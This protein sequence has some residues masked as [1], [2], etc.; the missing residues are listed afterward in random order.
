MTASHDKARAERWARNNRR[1]AAQDGVVKALEGLIYTST[2]EPFASWL[3]GRSGL[4]PNNSFNKGRAALDE[5]RAAEGK[6]PPMTEEETES[7]ERQG[8]ADVRRE[9]LEEPFD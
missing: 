7:E 6:T 3:A 1:A 9:S 8:A 5:L 2:V 4:P